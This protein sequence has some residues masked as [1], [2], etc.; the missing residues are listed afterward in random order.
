MNGLFLTLVISRPIHS[1]INA[2]IFVQIG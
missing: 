2:D 1:A